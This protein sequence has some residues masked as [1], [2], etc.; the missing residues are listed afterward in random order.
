M[1]ALLPTYEK[2]I[3]PPI[4]ETDLV[5]QTE[6]V[7]GMITTLCSNFKQID[8]IR[9]EI[10]GQITDKA[11]P[12]PGV[13][14]GQA[15]IQIAAC[16][17]NGERVRNCLKGMGFLKEKIQYDEIEINGNSCPVVFLNNSSL[18]RPLINYHN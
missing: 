1:S 3:Y 9:A 13:K 2:K 5:K 10:G 8:G 15:F 17:P 16:H 11:H 4:P 18:N 7:S 6:I 14:N 12:I